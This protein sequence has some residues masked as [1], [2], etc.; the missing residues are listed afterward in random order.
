MHRWHKIGVA[1]LLLLLG[2]CSGTNFVYN[3]LDFLVPWYMDDYVD[4][5]QQQRQHLDETLAPLLA[6]H[7]NQE[8]PQ[9]VEILDGIGEKLNRP[10]TPGD[11]AGIFS[12]LQTAWFRLEDRSLGWLLD[13]GADLSDAQ[14]AD[15]LGAL[16]KQQEEYQEEYLERSDKEF[17]QD[18]YDN[19]LDGVQD[20]L[21]TLSDEQRKLLRE[22]SYQLLRS[23]HAWLQEREEWLQ[24]LA[25]LLQRQ[26][27]WQ[28]RVREAVIDRREKIAPAY[29][30][31]F[32]HNMDV[33]YDALAKLLNGRTER[34]DRH[35][36]SKLA[37]LRE[38]LETLIAQGRQPAGSVEK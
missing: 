29:R 20:Y 3:R 5:N 36:R 28:Q 33:I 37:D 11:I 1:I 34:Q 8:L 6:W 17:Y 19:M 9:Y 21:G 22:A 16:G 14:V 13:L 23:D 10:L 32:E 4:L 18:S 26:P 7:R 27:G 12:E 25:V 15:F 30:R 2:A 24:R 35:L 38:D 31:I